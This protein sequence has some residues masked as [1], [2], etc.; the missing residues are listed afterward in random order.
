M[1][2]GNSLCVLPGRRG[3]AVLGL[4]CL[5]ASPALAKT[6]TRR[7]RAVT[8]AGKPV[9]GV[10]VTC[11]TH[12]NRKEAARAS[13]T[14][15]AD[16]LFSI[17]VEA[18][19]ES[20]LRMAV[21]GPAGGK[22]APCAFRGGRSGGFPP[23][24]PGMITIV[25]APATCSVAGTVTGGDGKPVPGVTVTLVLGDYRRSC[26]WVATTDKNGRY[27]IGRLAAASYAVRIV[28]PPAGS[29][30]IR[31][32]TWKPFGVRQVR[33]GGGTHRTEDFRLPR[34]ARLMGE[35]LDETGKP[36]GGAQ[37]SCSTDVATEVGKR[38][39]YQM[40]GQSYSA[41]ATTDEKGRYV[42]A[43]LT[44]ETYRVTV[45]PPPGRN[46][47]R[48]VLRGVNAPDGADISVQDVTL[49][50]GGT[51]KGVVVGPDGAPVNGASV[52][53]R[54]AAGYSGFM[55]VRLPAQPALTTD[56]AG[57]FSL[58]GLSSGTHTLVV[59]PPAGSPLSEK[60]FAALP[61][62]AGLSLKHTLRL[63]KGARLSGT[64][65]D[66]AGKPVAGA[67]LWLKHGSSNRGKATTAADGSFSM[68]G[69]SPAPSPSGG[70]RGPPT[71]TLRASPPATS[72]GLVNTTV[73]LKDIALGELRTAAVRMP[74]GVAIV[75]TVTGPDG[76]PVPGCRVTAYRR[77]GRGGVTYVQSVR[78][79]RQ[80]RYALGNVAANR[81]SIGAVPPD[82]VNLLAASVGPKPFAAGK[83]A[84]VDV[85]LRAGALI[86]GVVKTSG[87]RPVPA[88]QVRLEAG[89]SGRRPWIPG[90][91]HGGRQ[92]LSGPD[93]TFRFQGVLPGTYSFRCS[94]A[95]PQLRAGKATVTA[96]GTGEH[97][98]A[99]RVHVS[100]SAV[101]T[102]RDANGKPLAGR[103]LVYLKLESKQHGGRRGYPDEHGR[104]RM[105]G[106]LPGAYSA[107][108][109]LTRRG[110]DAG[111]IV[112]PPVAVVV[113]EGAEAKV[114]ITVRKR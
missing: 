95:N 57:R 11:T 55:R 96:A 10:N 77:V 36:V 53:A 18:H 84:T 56:A 106:L 103:G 58:P 17:T 46:L 49:Y 79:D 54:P 83:A 71:W 32:Y 69:L 42:L 60:A 4:L 15:D 97:R 43:A 88:A 93:G 24:D 62:V 65:T 75:G 59:V 26:T 99:I 76:K 70:R 73:T 9:P 8:L 38:S 33:L 35:V 52:S 98:V 68:A 81:W 47:A 113:K 31:L 40:P 48:A 6:V 51:L 112:P 104:A 72:P 22:L 50:R 92:A 16:G 14:T 20:S 7:G 45:A 23:G 90:M 27:K 109:T 67:T 108:V 39:I 86:L 66:P 21:E 74:A 94:F 85:R 2:I 19:R 101:V 28:D 1:T 82:D 87:G 107:T 44:Q 64:V 3:L 89:R 37:V 78:T 30:W 5:A 12:V 110:T 91:R 111:L 34:G 105:A 100:G 102:L 61:V 25:L 114:D 13:S 80:G 41:T 63:P 29:P